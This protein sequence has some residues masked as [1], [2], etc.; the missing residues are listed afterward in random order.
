M[1]EG[2]WPEWRCPRHGEPLLARPEALECA[3]GES[4]P[5]RD[6]IVR[7]VPERSYADAF[8]AQ[9]SRYR[10]TQLDSH[11][12]LP[13]AAER[14]RRCLGEEL[15]SGL[16]GRQVLEAGC[17]AGRFTEVLLAR[18]AH[19]TSI[20]LSN[21]VDSNQAGFPQGQRHRIAQADIQA[22]PFAERSFDLVV[23]LGVVQHTADPEDTIAALYGQVAPGGWLVFDHY[24]LGP[25]WLSTA[26]LFRAC[27]RRVPAEPGMRA[28][29]RLVA[30]LLPLHRRAAGSALASKLLHRLSPVL[31]Y[32]RQYPVLPENLQ[33]EWA[34]LDTHDN[35]TDW[36][37]HLRTVRQIER[38][39]TGLGLERIW[40]KPGGNGIEARGRRPIVHEV[41]AA[42]LVGAARPSA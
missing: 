31:T 10:L 21:A 35:L 20:D 8:G 13:I 9:W 18:G 33:H 40:C 34:L 38:T 7:F 24:A 32:Y 25:S 27:L 36:Y 42:P 16:E 37:K 11:T 15:W 1:T 23:C 4:F 19:V 2:A 29:E 17:G 12:G 39:L 6:G 3:R 5:I 26:L 14:L 41:A 28:T 22:A 30:V